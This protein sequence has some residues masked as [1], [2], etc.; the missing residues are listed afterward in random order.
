MLNNCG[1]GFTCGHNTF[2]MGKRLVHSLAPIMIAR[3]E[4]VISLSKLGANGQVQSLLQVLLATVG[5]GEDLSEVVVV[6]RWR[7][8][9]GTRLVE[10]DHLARDTLAG[11]GH[12][13]VDTPA[14]DMRFGAI[15]AAG[16]KGETP[17]ALGHWRRTTWAGVA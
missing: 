4:A 13:I 15:T 2:A 6:P 10:A 14:G 11:L 5:R 7:S 3:D 16:R 8:E 12:R 17:F 1:G 9:D